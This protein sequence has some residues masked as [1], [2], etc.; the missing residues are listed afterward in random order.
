MLSLQI[1]PLPMAWV[2]NC[3]R[4]QSTTPSSLLTHPC[5]LS[6]FHWLVTRGP[7][8]RP[9]HGLP[10]P[11]TIQAIMVGFQLVA[12]MLVGWS[13]GLCS[14][15]F[16]GFVFL[17][18][19]P[20]N[21]VISQHTKLSKHRREVVRPMSSCWAYLLLRVPFREFWP[22]QWWPPE[23]YDGSGWIPLCSDQM[24]WPRMNQALAS[25]RHQS[26]EC[27]FLD[28]THWITSY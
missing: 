9:F 7:S 20:G 24:P 17:D 3:S 1:S 13:D 14:L 19:G 10:L 21:Y 15:L 16:S 8:A 6:P 2:I 11:Y 18:P 12:S 27:L 4:C 26:Q 25:D 5:W 23:G 28:Y 22:S